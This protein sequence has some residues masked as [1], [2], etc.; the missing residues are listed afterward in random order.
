[1]QK[2]RVQKIDRNFPSEGYC[3]SG[4]IFTFHK[5][6]KRDICKNGEQFVVVSSGTDNGYGVF[7]F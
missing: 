1:M 4:F 3:A 6:F 7:D 5:T 2:G